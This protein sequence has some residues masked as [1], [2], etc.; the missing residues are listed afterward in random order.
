MLTVLHLGYRKGSRS[1][2]L[3]AGT[4]RMP[5]VFHHTAGVRCLFYEY[6]VLGL[7]TFFRL[8]LHVLH[9]AL[10]FVCARRGLTPAT[11]GAEPEPAV[12]A[13]G[14]SAI[15]LISAAMLRRDLTNNLRV[16]RK[17]NGSKETASTG[18]YGWRSTACARAQYSQY[19]SLCQHAW[20]NSALHTSSHLF[21]H[22]LSLVAPQI[23]SINSCRNPRLQRRPAQR[24][25]LRLPQI[26][27]ASWRS[28][29]LQRWPRRAT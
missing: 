23:D 25:T 15:H 11:A 20:D 17:Q 1:K 6:R 7:H 24:H 8:D 10:D 4:V 12:V 28:S 29:T 2:C 9:P 19:T 21:P 18:T 13:S 26:P 3:C 16:W 27:P 14:P 5:V 22:A